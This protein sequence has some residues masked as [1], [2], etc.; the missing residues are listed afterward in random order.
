MPNDPRLYGVD[1]NVYPRVPSPNDDIILSELDKGRPSQRLKKAAIG[2]ANSSAAKKLPGY[3]TGKNLGGIARAIYQKTHSSV[4]K[5][6]P[7]PNG[8]AIEDAQLSRMGKSA[9]APGSIRANTQ[10]QPPM[11]F[12]EYT[13]GEGPQVP[14]TPPPPPATPIIR[15]SPPPPAGSTTPKANPPRIPGNMGWNPPPPASLPNGTAESTIDYPDVES[16]VSYP[17]LEDNTPAPGGATPVRRPQPPRGTADSTVTSTDSTVS[18]PGYDNTQWQGGDPGPISSQPLGGTSDSTATT[19]DS[20]VTYPGVDDTKWK[21][22][23]TFYPEYPNWDGQGNPPPQGFDPD[24]MGYDNYDD[25]PPLEDV[26]STIDYG[27]PGDA[28]D[29]TWY[30]GGQYYGAG[31]V[32]EDD[33]MLMGATGLKVE[34]PTKALIGEG[35]Q[36]EYVVPEDKVQQFSEESLAT[37]EPPDPRDIPDAPTAP[38]KLGPPTPPPTTESEPSEPT[39]AVSAP[40]GPGIDPIGAAQARSLAVTP[41]FAPR[42]NGVATGAPPILKAPGQQSP[43]TLPEPPAI[44]KPKVWQRI[45]AG[46]LGAAAGIANNRRGV[47]PIDVSGAQQSILYPGR[48]REMAQYE[49]QVERQKQQSAMN[50]QA[51]DTTEAQARADYYKQQAAT[52]AE[53]GKRAPKG[54]YITFGHNNTG[55]FDANSG[56]EVRPPDVQSP[57]DYTY[58]SPD[59]AQAL[60]IEPYEPGKYRIPK[61]ATDAYLR[62]QSQPPKADRVQTPDQQVFDVAVRSVAAKH[63]VT[64]DPARPL[65]EQLPIALQGE[66]AQEHKRLNSLPPSELDIALK[67]A[68]LDQRKET[69]GTG[70]APE[71]T[72]G[73]PEFRVAQDLAYGKLTMQQFRSLYSYARNYQLKQAIYN[74]A[75]DLNPNFNPAAFEMGFT[76]AKNP[77][78]QQQLA[79]LDNVMQGV[80][81]LVKLSDEATRTGVPLINRLVVPGGALLG[82][83]KYSNVEKARIAFAD[84]LSGALGYGSA[85]DMSREMGLQLTDPNLSPDAFRSALKE[86]VIPFIERKRS[87]MLN[88]MGVYGQQGMNPAAGGQQPSPQGGLGAQGQRPSLNDIFK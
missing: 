81:D 59:R 84:E 45:A 49:Q 39:A 64:L 78:V 10:K 40:R 34:E 63:G 85:T 46:A 21:G 79:S 71:I 8:G 17:G 47:A 35:G 11:G 30:R 24:Q 22:T 16:T 18:F 73:T 61:T 26:T 51:A 25:T 1:P 9:I 43:P 12:E 65:M 86:V 27:D 60:G 48:G 76:L 3:D 41:T 55:I 87:T 54:N 29:D 14:T 88:Q 33:M 31:D 58:I 53:E 70:A 57:D 82:G 37:G 5:S 38:P 69:S 77:K 44:R 50:K 4:I 83:K 62:G 13:M 66:A 20:T 32:G 23:T 68:L 36:P 15:S 75:A 19:T 52:L 2:A 80:P 72:Q 42:N 56:K 7:K 6:K 67:Q 28:E 74:K